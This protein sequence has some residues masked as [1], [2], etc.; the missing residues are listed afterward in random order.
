[1]PIRHTIG[2]VPGAYG[3]LGPMKEWEREKI[4]IKI[5]NRN[6]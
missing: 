4:K 2:A 3:I 6:I 1:L 5:K